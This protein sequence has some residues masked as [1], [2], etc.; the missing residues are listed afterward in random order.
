MDFARLRNFMSVVNTGSLRRAAEICHL[1]VSALSRQIQG[2]EHEFGT[3]L[4]ERRA[5]GMVLTTEGRIVSEHLGR[6]LREMELARAC[7]ADLRGL[8]IGT[9]VVASIEGVLCSWLLP[10]VQ[11]FQR[12]HPGVRID[13][14]VMGSDAVYRDLADD[15]AD[16]GV[17]LEGAPHADVDVLERFSTGFRVAMAPGHPLSTRRCLRLADLAGH[18]LAL[19]DERFHTYQVLAGSSVWPMLASQVSVT[20]NQIEMI[21]SHVQV[22]SAVT[23]LPDYAVA[24]EARDGSLAVADIHADDLPRSHTLLCVRHGRRMTTAAVRLLKHFRDARDSVFIA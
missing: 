11:A 22:T 1:S 4:F 10:A 21:K 16:V 13:L 24:N 23:V 15:Q 14:K 17:A 12:D 9:V 19:L 18:P 7:I 6:T 5:D 2:L 3:P 20:M 8:V